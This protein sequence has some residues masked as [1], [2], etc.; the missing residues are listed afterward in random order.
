MYVADKCHHAMPINYPPKP[1]VMDMI[2]KFNKLKPPKYKGRSDPLVYE[3]C[4]RKM[5]LFK[6]VECLERF[7]V[8]STTFQF[9]CE[10]ECW[11][12]NNQTQAAEPPLKSK[13]LKTLT[14]A[15]YYPKDV[16]MA[17][18]QEF[19]YLKQGKHMNMMA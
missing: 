15:K 5:S 2:C 6:I 18:E 4:L 14:D 19:L 16:N 8:H 7:E 17:K 1:I 13:Q 10:A 9:R 3:E 12:K 11:S